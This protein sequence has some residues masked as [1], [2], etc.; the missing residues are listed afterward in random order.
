MVYGS[1]FILRGRVSSMFDWFSVIVIVEE[2]RSQPSYMS[3]FKGKNLVEIEWYI[4]YVP[5]AAA[6]T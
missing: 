5:V 1:H 4:M 6:E 3:R 2:S